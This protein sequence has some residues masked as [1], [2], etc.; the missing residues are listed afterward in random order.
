MKILR[1]GI[2]GMVVMSIE[3][4]EKLAEAKVEIKNGAQGENFM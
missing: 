2:G 1:N 3:M 4:F